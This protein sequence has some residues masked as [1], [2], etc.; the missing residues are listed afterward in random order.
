MNSCWVSL[1]RCWRCC[2]CTVRAAPHAN[3][4]LLLGSR[5]C[6]IGKL[7]LLLEKVLLPWAVAWGLWAVQLHEAELW[8]L[9]GGGEGAGASSLA[10][11]AA[12]GVHRA[13]LWLL[14]PRPMAQRALPCVCM[15]GAG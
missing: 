13:G 2:Y 3:A 15:Y 12:P 5:D 9:I 7:L 6:R 8:P 14:L 10:G 11:R 1:R 4:W